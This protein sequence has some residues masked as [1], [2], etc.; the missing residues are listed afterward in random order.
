MITSLGLSGNSS[1]KSVPVDGHI[2]N[3]YGLRN[4]DTSNLNGLLSRSTRELGCDARDFDGS[5]GFNLDKKVD[6]PTPGDPRNRMS[7][8]G[9]TRVYGGGSVESGTAMSSLQDYLIRGQY[10]VEDCDKSRYFR[11][12]SSALSDRQVHLRMP[13]MPLRPHKVQFPST[14]IQNSIITVILTVCNRQIAKDNNVLLCRF[15]VT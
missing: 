14:N 2:R 13:T 11:R 1:T 6:F 10:L 7:T 4:N 8:S 3:V 12:L 9:I 15:Y 5:C